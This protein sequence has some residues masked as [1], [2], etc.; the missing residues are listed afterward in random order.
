MD[1]PRRIP[2]LTDGV[3]TLRPLV[4]D[5]I[6]A[7]LAASQDPLTAAFT[8]VP[9]PYTEA[10]A[11]DFVEDRAVKVWPGFDVAIV[12]ADDRFLGLCGLRDE[13]DDAVTSIGYAVAPWARGAG[14]ATRATRLLIAFSWQIGAVRVGL[15]VYADN[16]A[17]RAVARRCGFTQEGVLRSA[18]LGKNGRR[19]D[20]VKYGL[21]KTDS[22]VETPGADR[23]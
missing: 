2:T 20:L 22:I 17:S 10:D 12:D 9:S 5:D 16:A 15:D 3:V 7:V 6:D 11:R 18:A 1:W 4:Y 19:H 23:P 21:L 13:D 8:V 14:I